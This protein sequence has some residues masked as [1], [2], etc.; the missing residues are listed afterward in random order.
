[1]KEIYYR[2]KEVKLFA[3]L[4][5]SEYDNALSCLHAKVKKYKKGR[6]L[7]LTGDR[8]KNI[9]IVLE[10]CIEIARTDYVGN[11]LIV[12]QIEYP[13]MFGEAFV[14]A[15]VT[16]S[17]ITLTALEDSIVLMIDFENISSESAY[18]CRYFRTMVS[19][20]LGTMAEKNLFLSYR[21][22]LV[23]KKTIRAKL[24]A[25]L[26][27]I[28]EMTNQSDIEIPYNR[29]QLA[30]YLGVNRSAMS[31]E[32]CKMREKEILDFHKN[33]FIIHDIKT[34]S[35]IANHEDKF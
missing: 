26:T 14:F 34:L 8:I 2:L 20:L 31:H 17:P 27:H 11:R 15:K 3:G 23:T 12:N 13:N 1:V 22:E 5:E 7:Q 32:L 4:D 30:D 21:L 6:I 35:E 10:G 16:Q 25:Y 18:I 19:N 28:I 9:G 29:N 33:R 24:A